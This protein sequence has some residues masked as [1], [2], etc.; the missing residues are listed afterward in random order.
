M[1]AARVAGVLQ[2]VHVAASDPREIVV[3][4]GLGMGEGIVAGAVGADLITVAKDGDL[5]E[6]TPKAEKVLSDRGAGLNEA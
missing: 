2:T 1:V 4:A 3:N 5:Y 6:L